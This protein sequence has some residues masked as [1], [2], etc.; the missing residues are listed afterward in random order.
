MEF[1]DNKKEEQKKIREDPYNY[2]CEYVESIYPKTG[3]RVFEV[4]SLMPPSLIIPDFSFMGK[5]IRSNIH[6]L[7]LASSGAGK[8]SLA[9]LFA[10]FT[11]F[12][13]KLESVTSA[14]LENII[15]ESP[16]FSLIVG[17]FARMSSDRVLIKVI[18][19]LL[20]EEKRVSRK[21][22]RKDLDIDTEGIGLLCGVSTDLSRYVLGGIIFRVVPILLHHTHKEHSQIG[23]HIVDNI[24]KS[25]NQALIEDVII[26]YYRELSF[27]QAGKNKEISLVQDYHIEK[28]FKEKLYEEWNELTTPIIKE[29]YGFN[30]FRELQEGIRILISHAFLNIHNRKCENG[31]LYPNEEDFKIA[32]RLMR[33]TIIFKYRLMKTEKMAQG[34]SNAKEFVRVMNSESV[35]EDTK[36]ILKNLVTI[37]N[38][39]VVKREK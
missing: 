19:G 8:T 9:D 23:K 3:R 36:N 15:N 39:R 29:G 12:P 20:G 35:S 27:I 1:T 7:F 30:F 21:T 33:Q 11:F 16:F 5:K 18:E 22:M 24:G 25:T 13:L 17:D 38:G 34:L 4:L 26:E 32:L 28:K 14:K 2:I 10:V 31:I 6:A 37:K